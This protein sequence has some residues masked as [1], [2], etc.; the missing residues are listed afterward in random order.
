MNASKSVLILGATSAIAVATARLYARQGV[1]FVLVARDAAKLDAVAK[2]LQV[3]GAA[4]VHSLQEDFQDLPNHPRIIERAQGHLGKIDVVLLAYGVVGERGLPERNAAAAEK[5]MLTNY[6]SPVSLLTHLA[7]VFETQ[8]SGAIAVIS[9]VAGDRGRLSNYVYGSSKAGL[10]CFLSGY[11]ARLL[12]AGVSVITIKPGQIDTPM[13]RTFKK[14]PIWVGPERIAPGILRAIAKG[15][16]E[17]Y[18][19]GFWRGIMLI[20]RWIPECI[21]KR[22]SL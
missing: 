15:K 10:N 11:R 8:R 4:E 20:I 12:R 1:R 22:S 9:S 18:L 6:L 16:N 17:V 14:T 19:P 3:R 7:P 5:V 21:F 13:T 2:D